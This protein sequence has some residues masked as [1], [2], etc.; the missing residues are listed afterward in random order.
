[1]RKTQFLAKL[2]P[3]DA[4][5]DHLEISRLVAYYDFPWD[6]TRALELALFRTFAVPSIG[7]LLYKTQEFTRRTQ[8]RYDDTDLLLSEIIEHGYDSERGQAALS[9]MNQ[10]HG[11]F[12]ISN[13][14]MLYVLSTFV[15]EPYRWNLRFGY[16]ISTEKELDAGHRL[17]FEMGTRMGITAIPDTFRALEQFNIAYE[18]VHFSY[19]EGGRKVADATLNLML[20]WFLPRFCW[21]LARPFVL[22]IMD[23]PLLQALQYPVPP[24]AF[25]LAINGLMSIRKRMLAFIPLP[26]QPK[27]HTKKK[28][29]TY[30]Q[31]Y[32]LEDLG[33][34]K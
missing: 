34:K 31:G 13:E 15:I 11:H 23:E 1:M 3:L 21:P 29:R 17:W 33:A 10:L 19:S 18:K 14:D 6:T 25:R 30:A 2:A 22:A 16:R 32:A 7:N 4:Q 5:A 8:K 9:R 12:H 24:K 26:K 28:N 27:L 20:S